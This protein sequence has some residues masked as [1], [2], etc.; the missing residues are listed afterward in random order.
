MT[1]KAYRLLK[2]CRYEVPSAGLVAEPLPNG[3]F[4]L[5]PSGKVVEG[6]ALREALRELW[7]HGGAVIA[8]GTRHEPLPEADRERL[9]QRMAAEKAAAAS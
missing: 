6:A 5:R 3:N 2:P 1:D 4:R 7:L 8:G 9:L